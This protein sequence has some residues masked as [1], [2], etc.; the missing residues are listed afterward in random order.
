MAKSQK[1]V[2]RLTVPRRHVLVAA[3]AV[4]NDPAR[5]LLGSICFRAADP[6]AA[7]TGDMEGVLRVIASNGHKLVSMTGGT[8]E[9]EWPR[10]GC[11]VI[12]PKLFS[13]AKPKKLLDTYITVQ[14][15]GDGSVNVLDNAAGHQ[16]AGDGVDSRFLPYPDVDRVLKRYR[17]YAVSKAAIGL[18]ADYLEQMGRITH[19][20]QDHP[21]KK[22]RVVLRRRNVAKNGTEKD[23]C[24]V[25]DGTATSVLN[26]RLD[27]L[28]MGLREV[29]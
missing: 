8:W 1:E 28:L 19:L 14:C 24:P 13:R 9:G 5:T 29:A 17:R 10:H 11:V 25:F 2:L 4:S 22:M 15:F 23:W 18:R 7:D 27:V 20:F 12:P 3:L 16:A 6:D 26:R 21:L